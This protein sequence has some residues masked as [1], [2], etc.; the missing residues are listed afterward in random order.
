MPSR[1]KMPS[2]HTIAVDRTAE[3]YLALLHDRGIDDFF[4]NEETAFGPIVELL[5]KSAS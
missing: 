3:A 1:S 5:A 4:G 2:K